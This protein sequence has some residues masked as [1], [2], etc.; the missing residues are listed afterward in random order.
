[1]NFEGVSLWSGG[2]PGKGAE[3]RNACFLWEGM[4]GSP[5]ML[6]SKGGRP[7]GSAKVSS[8][9]GTIWGHSDPVVQMHTL[10]LSLP[11][12]AFPGHPD[13]GPQQCPLASIRVPQSYHE[14]CIGPVPGGVREE[15]AVSAEGAGFAP[16]WSREPL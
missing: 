3:A 6:E 1:M 16:G 8:S 10:S 13:K 14:P 2:C 5:G 11:H 15:V 4:R 9:L 12:E 7:L